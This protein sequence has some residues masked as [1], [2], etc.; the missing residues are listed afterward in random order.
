MK[1]YDF[2]FRWDR[3][4]PLFGQCL[5][6]V[7][8]VSEFFIPPPPP[9]PPPCVCVC[10]CVL[11]VKS[12][13]LHLHRCITNIAASVLIIQQ[14]YCYWMSLFRLFFLSFSDDVMMYRAR[15]SR[16][17]KI[18]KVATQCQYP[19]NWE[20]WPISHIKQPL[21]SIGYAWIYQTFQVIQ[22]LH[23]ESDS[24]V[25]RPSNILLTKAAKYWGRGEGFKKEMKKR[26]PEE[27]FF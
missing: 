24:F 20:T 3:A 7:I 23:R 13:S 12:L 5:E 22:L 9:P 4:K 19:L 17:T 8:L 16:P 11:S 15:L 2:F 25:C 27:G 18:Q 21:D 6:A 26:E 10:V 1:K 14:L